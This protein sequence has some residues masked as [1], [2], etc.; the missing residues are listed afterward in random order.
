MKYKVEWWLHEEVE[1]DSE[2][3]AVEKAICQVSNVDYFQN[4]ELTEH[5]KWHASVCEIYED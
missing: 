1:A 2:E 5:I 3:E 4:N